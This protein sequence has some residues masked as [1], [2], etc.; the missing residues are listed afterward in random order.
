MRPFQLSDRVK[1]ADTVGD[2][3][4]KTLLVTRVR[5][6]KNVDIT[7]PNSLILGAHIINYSS[8]SLTAPPLILNTSV[9]LGYDAPW[10]TVHELL[11]KAA[12]ATRNI[13]GPGAVR[14]ANGAQ[15]LLCR[16]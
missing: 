13:L 16:L 7:I 14:A 2:V 1:I 4:E 12:L 9:T 3:T 8:T 6:I 10:R 15:R 11:K 5:T